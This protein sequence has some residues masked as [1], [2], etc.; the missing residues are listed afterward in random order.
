MVSL[1]VLLSISQGGLLPLHV[2]VM[3]KADV[4][5]VALLLKTYP[6]AASKPDKPEVRTHGLAD[7]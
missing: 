1:C 4:D 7:L 5:V 2:A 6:D 3:H